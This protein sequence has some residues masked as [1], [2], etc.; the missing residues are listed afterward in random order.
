LAKVLHLNF[1]R[2]QFTPDLLPSDL[3][4][5]MIYN[6][7]QSIFEVKKG[8]SLPTGAG[9]RNQPLARQGPERLARSHAGKA[10]HHRRT[11]YPL[12]CRF[13]VLATQN[14]VEQKAPTRCPKPRSTASC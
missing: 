2:V 10:G 1:Q 7:N 4:G 11:T 6:Q 8:P 9:R 13:L 3:V 14:P 5:T 12:D